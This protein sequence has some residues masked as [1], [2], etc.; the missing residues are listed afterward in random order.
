MLEEG[1]PCKEN[2]Y[3]HS[4]AL[5]IQENIIRDLVIN[6]VG[7]GKWG[8]GGRVRGGSRGKVR[9]LGVGLFRIPAQCRDC[10]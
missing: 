4:M 10:F 9:T 1:I 8:E 6:G 3:K 7:C 2:I 5:H